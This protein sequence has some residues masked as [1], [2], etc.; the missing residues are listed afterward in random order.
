MNRHVSGLLLATGPVVDQLLRD[1]LPLR[2]LLVG[3][4]PLVYSHLLTD[5]AVGLV[6]DGLSVEVGRGHCALGKSPGQAE[7]T[8]LGVAI[9]I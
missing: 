3:G 2:P 7:V 8:H 6:P 4:G 9:G 5:D 1:E